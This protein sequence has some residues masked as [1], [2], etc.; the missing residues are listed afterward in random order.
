MPRTLNSILI[1]FLFFCH[2]F[3]GSSFTASAQSW[4]W[5]R[6]DTGAFIDGTA[7]AVDALGN[8]FGGGTIFG[9]SGGL[10]SGTV[11][12][13]NGVSAP[14][15]N[16][17]GFWVKYDPAGNAQWVDIAQ[18][19]PG[20]STYISGMATDTAKNLIVFGNLLA[21]SVQVGTYNLTAAAAGG[22]NPYWLAKVS[23]S[24]TVLWAI[25]AGPSGGGGGGVT[26]DDT[27]NIYIVSC[28]SAATM[29]IGTYTLVN[30]GSLDLFVGKYSPS[31]NVLWASSVGGVE[32]EYAN[33]ISLNSAG[34]VY[35]VGSFLSP[36]FTVGSSVLTNPLASAYKDYAFVAEFSPSGVP[37]WG[38]AAGGH[39]HAAACSI[40]KDNFDNIFVTGYFDTSA[41]TFGS[42][43]IYSIY[44]AT[45][46]IPKYNTFL[47]E[48]SPANIATWGMC[49]TSPSKSV[50]SEDVAVSPCGTQVWVCGN[51]KEN[52]LVDTGVTLASVPDPYPLDEGYIVGYNIGGGLVGD[53]GFG[54]GAGEDQCMIAF[55][56]SG[57]MFYSADFYKQ[58]C[59]LVFG[60]DTLITDVQEAFFMAKYANVFLHDTTYATHDTVLCTGISGV[61]LTAPAGYAS[62][63][64][65]NDSATGSRTITGPGTYYVYC[66]ECSDVL[67]DTFHVIA[68]TQD[69]TYN[70][71][72]TSVC[73]TVSSVTLSA[74]PGYVSYLWSTGGTSS[75][76]AVN[77]GGAYF[78]S[79][80]SGCG[81]LVD[82][83]NV[84]LVAPPAIALVDDTIFCANNTVTLSSGQPTG[85]TYLWNTGS[86]ASSI[87]VSGV[88]TWW[89]KV[90]DLYGC[91]ATDTAHV[92][93][94]A[95]TNSGHLTN[96]TPNETIAYGSSIQLNADGEV[97]YMWKPDDGSLS[98]PNIN[99]PISTPIHTTLYTVF[100]YD[101][102]NCLDSAM[103]TI[104]VDST[105]NECI[106]SA[107]T[108]NGDGL[109][110]IF[111]PTCIKFQD[112]IDFS[113]YNRWGQQVFYSN[114]FKKGWDGTFNGVPQDVGTYFY[115][116]I[117]A[118]SG[119]NNVIYKGDV[120]LI[121]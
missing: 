35:V 62:Y 13:G 22:A 67:V 29:T 66:I 98:N 97:I 116:I 4:A 107:F 8:S 40:T 87:V 72:D 80:S 19:P 25:C 71:R 7:L 111:R 84:F 102:H 79:A 28:F 103:V 23:P 96:V 52:T 31:G 36:S 68:G 56:P 94:A 42:K 10:S 60:P 114:T 44:P 110:D 73:N 77:A 64:W 83:I 51:Y 104:Y 38:Q 100:G 17:D 27:G 48:Y 65:D 69:T 78:V 119:G 33:G 81:L 32:Q 82:T 53:M 3:F 21:S 47:I 9:S 91:S 59:Q 117:V 93:L 101:L 50:T 46:V 75:S 6:K 109:N 74:P 88:G 55:D 20:G 113:V 70:G 85:S 12:F 14:Q 30:H 92:I 61:A 89:L 86:I 115:V 58:P 63:L 118:K 1:L 105:M 49:I 5:G 16:G 54:A 112:I 34:D 24:G 90:T 121:R 2:F 39:G 120:T 76:I 57:N 99:N 15:T 11:Y 18:V 37:L 45:S 41:I 26:T 108:P 43:T 106:P 95:N